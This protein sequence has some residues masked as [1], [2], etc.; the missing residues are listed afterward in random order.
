MSG[1]RLPV[2][3]TRIVS[4]VRNWDSEKW[5]PWEHRHVTLRFG[6]GWSERVEFT[7]IMER[8]RLK[9]RETHDGINADRE[10]RGEAA[11]STLEYS[12][13]EEAHRVYAER[14]GELMAAEL[15]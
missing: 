11:L 9:H 13:T 8:F 3:I 14:Y 4:D 7:A 15:I 10:R 6:L 1:K 2:E 12:T 5:G